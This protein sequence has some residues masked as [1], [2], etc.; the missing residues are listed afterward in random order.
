MGERKHV[1]QTNLDEDT[2]W[3]S[4]K[5]YFVGNGPCNGICGHWA[6]FC[7]FYPDPTH[8]NANDSGIDSAGGSGSDSRSDIGSDSR[9]DSNSGSDNRS[10]GGSGRVADSGTVC[11]TD[12]E[13]EEDNPKDR[14]RCCTCRAVELTA[15]DPKGRRWNSNDWM[16]YKPKEQSVESFIKNN[17]YKILGKVML[18]TS[19]RELQLK[20]RGH[21]MNKTLYDLG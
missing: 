20:C 18:H 5:A 10:D 2:N 13:V 1:R 15:V 9:G 6:L 11:G 12:N 7:V 19:P 16:Y 14:K 17:G 21:C 8:G 3:R 4:A